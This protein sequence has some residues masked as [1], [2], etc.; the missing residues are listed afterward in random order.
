[1]MLNESAGYGNSSR[2]SGSSYLAYELEPARN[3][4]VVWKHEENY[5]RFIHNGEVTFAIR[6]ISLVLF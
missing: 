5:T 1:M 6:V 2:F 4:L 3:M